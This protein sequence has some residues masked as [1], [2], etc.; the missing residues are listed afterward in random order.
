MT[1]AVA[2]MSATALMALVAYM[3]AM[4]GTMQTGTMR[5]M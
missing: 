1:A 5:S 2:T 4:P 3:T